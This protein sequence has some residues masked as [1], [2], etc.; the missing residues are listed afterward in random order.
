MTLNIK[1]GINFEGYKYENCPTLK[2]LQ[3][4]YKKFTN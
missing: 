1:Y 3:I 2:L 4:F